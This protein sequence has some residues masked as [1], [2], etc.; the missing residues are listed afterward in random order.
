MSQILTLYTTP[1]V[2]LYLDRLRHWRRCAAPAARRAA[3]PLA[4]PPNEVRSGIA[5][6]PARAAHWAAA[7]SGPITRV[8]PSRRRSPSRK[9]ATG[10]TAPPPSR[11]RRAGARPSRMTGPSAAT[12][13]GC[14]RTRPST[15]W[16]AS[17]TSTA[18]PCARR[19]RATGRPAPWSAQARAALYPTVIGAPGISRV[20][21]GGVERT[22]RLA[23]GAGELGAG[24]VRRH[25][26]QHRERG[27]RGPVR[28]GAGRGSSRLSVQAEV[29]TNY[30]QLRYADALQRLLNETVEAYKRT[31]AITENQY[32]AGVAARSDVIT[33]RP[34]SRPRGPGHRGRP[35]AGDLRARHR[36][37]H[38]APALRG[39]DPGGEPRRPPARGA[40]RHPFRYLLERRP[41]RGPGRAHRAGQS[42]LIGVAVAAFYP[43]VTLSASGGI[44]GD[45]ATACSRRPTRSGRW[46]P[47]APR[48][49]STA[50]RA[51]RRSASRAAYDAA[52]ANY[53]QVVLTAF[54]EVENGM[55][56]VRILA[57]QQ[58]A[59]DA[60]VASARRAVRSPS[61]ST[62]PA[63]RTSPR[64]HRPGARP[65]QRG[66]GAPGQAQPL[67]HG[68]VADP[69]PRG[70]LG[71]AQPAGRSGAPRGP[72]A[73]RRRP[74]GAHR[75]VGRRRAQAPRFP[76]HGGATGRNA[77]PHRP[78]DVRS[79]R[80]SLRRVRSH[81]ELA[82][83]TD[84]HSQRACR[85]RHEGRPALHPRDLR[86]RGRPDQAPAD[87]CALQ[88]SG[89]GLLAEGFE[90]DW[91]STTTTT[92][93]RACART[94]HDGILRRSATSEFHADRIDPKAGASC[95][96]G[97]IS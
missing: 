26:P 9:A 61:T 3:A 37:P 72:P 45:R 56:G 1:V 68:G 25:P 89:A 29:V 50:A 11:R 95:G 86:G 78:F 97:S 34:R 21:A 28:R 48:F 15:G 81:P 60:A 94:R 44:S 19:W 66:H 59:Q 4:P 32:N 16:C 67:H 33:R 54:T 87:A 6:G 22:D 14:S 84:R 82:D 24:P 30:L 71:R 73:D 80:L 2:Y 64:Y 47:P 13:G 88:S 43:T 55:A 38:R 18:R 8:P 93:T 51:R 74:G 41:G 92:A 96:T 65:Q 12:G 20:P 35:A 52:V 5:G 63:P 75:R 77:P 31:L 46:R 27:R 85:L 10:R 39:L 57:R 83:G 69:G 79:R 91:A 23:P 70:R 76:A 49:C 53:R 90:E 42:E 7:W 62:G 58:A 36:A 40:G 17:S